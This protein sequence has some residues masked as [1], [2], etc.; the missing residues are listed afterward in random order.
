VL[1]TI[2]WDGNNLMT[3]QRLCRIL[4]RASHKTL[5]MR[6]H[7]SPCA[8]ESIHLRSQNDYLFI[9]SKTPQSSASCLRPKAQPPDILIGSQKAFPVV[10][11][12]NFMRFRN[13]NRERTIPP[14]KSILF[15][16]PSRSN[17]I[18]NGFVVQ[19]RFKHPL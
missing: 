6:G 14:L 10:Q 8:K 11:L 2:R 19:S 17:S 3:S 15:M 18:N 13:L 12:S 4:D 1:E 7:Y 9:Q 16:K 5:S